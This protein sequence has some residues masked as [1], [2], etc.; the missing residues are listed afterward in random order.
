MSKFVGPQWTTL[1]EKDR[2]QIGQGYLSALAFDAPIPAEPSSHDLLAPLMDP[3]KTPDS[4]QDAF[5]GLQ[6]NSG[7]LSRLIWNVDRAANNL[8][9][10][11]SATNGADQPLSKFVP[12]KGMID[13]DADTYFKD[14]AKQLSKTSQGQALL[15]RWITG[16]FDGVVDPVQL[17][18]QIGFATAETQLKEQS[19]KL[20][21]GEAIA[22]GLGNGL[23]EVPVLLGAL[24]AVKLGPVLWGGARATL[25]GR[26]AQNIQQGLVL[27]SLNE[28]GMLAVGERT[29]EDAMGNL[30]AG[31]AFDAV[32]AGVWEAAFRDIG[33]TRPLTAHDL[34]ERAG[35]AEAVSEKVL[36][37]EPP[38]ELR[39]AL[40][41]RAAAYAERQK[42]QEYL[43]VLNFEDFTFVPAYREAG[44][45]KIVPA[46][47][48]ADIAGLTNLKDWKQGL[49]AVRNKDAQVTRF[50]TLEEIRAIEE[51]HQNAQARMDQNV[52]TAEGNL[53]KVTEP[54]IT[55]GLDDA[56]DP[57][58]KLSDFNQISAK[59]IP[60][61]PA[62]QA[63]MFSNFGLEGTKNP[64]L[65][66]MVTRTFD[67]VR[68][69]EGWANGR[70]KGFSSYE[71]RRTMQQAKQSRIRARLERQVRNIIAETAG[72][73]EKLTLRSKV[74]SNEPLPQSVLAK[75]QVVLEIMEIERIK[76]QLTHE[77]Y[78]DAAPAEGQVPSP[79]RQG[80]ALDIE[81]YGA[82]VMREDDLFAQAERLGLPNRERMQSIIRDFGKTA[83]ADI[84]FLYGQTGEALGRQIDKAR[85]AILNRYAHVRFHEGD[86][87]F[88]FDGL[89]Q[90]MGIIQKR[91]GAPAEVVLKDFINTTPGGHNRLEPSDLLPENRNSAQTKQRLTQLWNEDI[92]G[93]VPAEHVPAVVNLMP[94]ARLSVMR[95][96]DQYMEFINLIEAHATYSHAFREMSVADPRFRSR[97]DVSKLTTKLDQGIERFTDPD[98]WKYGTP[99]YGEM[100]SELQKILSTL[101]DHV[102]KQATEIPNDKGGIERVQKL[103]TQIRRWAGLEGQGVSDFDRK[104]ADIIGNMTRATLL[105][106]AGVSQTVDTATLLNVAAMNG[107]QGSMRQLLRGL[108]QK[109]N[110]LGQQNPALRNAF[111]RN[112]EL[113]A[114]THTSFATQRFSAANYELDIDRIAQNRD[115][116]GMGRG[117]TE[118]VAGVI[119]HMSGTD[120]MNV[121][122]KG[123][124]LMSVLHELTDPEVGI[125]PKLKTA[126]E[127][128]EKAQ[129]NDIRPFLTAQGISPELGELT[130]RTLNKADV[131]VLTRK[132]ENGEF[133]NVNIKRRF[134]FLG[135]TDDSVRVVSNPQTAAEAEAIEK[136]AQTAN[137]LIDKRIAVPGAIEANSRPSGLFQEMAATFLRQNMA[138]ATRMLI[139]SSFRPALHRMELL[140]TL[141]G[142][143][144]IVGFTKALLNGTEEDWL[145][146]ATEHPARMVLDRL[147]WSGA[148]GVIGEK[149]ANW[150]L[151]STAD[152][153]FKRM[154]A[155]EQQVMFPGQSVIRMY[156]E[157]LGG[158]MNSI[159]SGSDLTPGSVSALWRMALVGETTI[160]K[161]VQRVFNL[162]RDEEDAFD[163]KNYFDDVLDATLGVRPKKEK[164]H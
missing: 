107:V 30:A 82:L 114:E 127:Q 125:V 27:S 67:R 129:G 158:V 84:S 68:T 41:Q 97:D 2:E 8:G 101:Q 71:T 94:G 130:L 37:D 79:Q 47:S 28:G 1:P 89:V 119:S 109:W 55:T 25:L 140:L 11:R 53:T 36:A 77:K 105:T 108:M 32:A 54:P 144:M 156:G 38:A 99:P 115:S 145:K 43:N 154:R 148:L 48:N 21:Q 31:A 141:L 64:A 134:S 50:V 161:G 56:I 72:P 6:I 26:V 83:D 121:A 39:E 132:I 155:G 104:W 63:A 69:I 17:A 113:T 88:T 139:G 18:A 12:G 120:M 111:F 52:Q 138:V 60:F 16:D 98:Q 51:A 29:V 45:G 149:A 136:L 40:A 35:Q 4:Y 73:L 42:S 62:R 146:T 102:S 70:V 157:G 142:G 110:D 85:R 15:D 44:T 33:R 137:Y 10:Y 61:G 112:L 46:T 34:S 162:I 93:F 81:K 75:R 96:L 92:G 131:D 22:L 118:G 124:A 57:N 153:N 23:L 65:G 106:K 80:M 24:N 122:N 76:Q 91:P 116:L 5:N 59:D 7:I 86:P 159:F 143:S 126:L 164:P 66:L 13:Y 58:L 90:L 160:V 74:V 3:Y 14:N 151:D 100:R 128:M 117:I 20:G 103:F 95:T 150:A 135:M 78:F 87:S 9:W 163:A 49:L 133:D 19:A 147:A 123:A 152:E